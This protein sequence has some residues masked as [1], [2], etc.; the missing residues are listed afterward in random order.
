[1]ERLT[2][3]QW[4]QPIAAGHRAR[5]QWA[6]DQ[7]WSTETVNDI[8]CGIGY[9]AAIITR[10]RAYHGYDRGGVHDDRFPGTF[11]S[12]DLDNIF[13][14]PDEADVTVCF[15]TLEH[16]KFPTLVARRIA[17]ATRSRIFVSAPTVPTKH[18]N[19][20]HLHDFT[21][22]DIPPMF[23][24]FIVTDVWEQPDERSHVWRLERP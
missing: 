10:R 6:A 1:M 24:R 16:L 5:Y 11:H 14:K 19:P 4:D 21:V 17:K 13:W 23:P 15:E 2:Y 9:G 22:E 18:E 8:A 20:Y 7:I 12:C 3:D